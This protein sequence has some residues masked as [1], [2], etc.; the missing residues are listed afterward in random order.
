VWIEYPK[1]NKNWKT[2]NPEIS[3][4]ADFS[5]EPFNNGSEMQKF[6]WPEYFFTEQKGDSR[7]FSIPSG[8][9]AGA[10][11]FCRLIPYSFFPSGL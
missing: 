4:P 3:E 6:R 11:Y 9:R 5:N 7:C 10:S 8:E 2:T 1:V